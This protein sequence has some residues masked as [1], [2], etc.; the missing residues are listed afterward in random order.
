MF[1]SHDGITSIIKGYLDKLLSRV[2][3]STPNYLSGNYLMGFILNG[4]HVVYLSFRILLGKLAYRYGS[5]V[6]ERYWSILMNGHNVLPEVNLT[7]HRVDDW[8][9]L[10]VIGNVLDI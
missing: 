3:L 7:R 5:T 9:T 2:V 4:I 1:R 6:H 8:R 10:E